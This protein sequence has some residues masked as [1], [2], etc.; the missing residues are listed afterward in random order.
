MNT[1]RHASGLS[2]K[3]LEI[4]NQNVIRI[5]FIVCAFSVFAFNQPILILVYDTL[6]IRVTELNIV[7]YHMWDAASVGVTLACLLQT[8]RAWMQS[9][10]HREIPVTSGIPAEIVLVVAIIAIIPPAAFLSGYCLSILSNSMEK[11]VEYYHDI[12]SI[13]LTGPNAIANS[14]TFVVTYIASSRIFSKHW[15]KQLALHKSE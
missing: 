12:R 8:H 1:L 13:A 4:K 2:S 5:L 7:L 15:K 6:D 3:I 14:L 10:I 9:A 11:T